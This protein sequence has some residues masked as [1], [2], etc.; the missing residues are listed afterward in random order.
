MLKK[1][2]ALVVALMMAIA[3][4]AMADIDISTMTDEELE[5]LIADAR[6]ELDSR[7]SN[8]DG[9]EDVYRFPCVILDVDGYKLEVL[10]VSTSEYNGNAMVNLDVIA[11]NTSEYDIEIDLSLTTIGEW[12]F[13][14]KSLSEG[15]KVKSGKKSKDTMMF[16]IRDFDVASVLSSDFEF[17][18]SVW[19]EG[20]SLHNLY[21]SA[22]LKG[23]FE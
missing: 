5:A 3:G 13:S 18:V 7:R 17:E 15:V 14:D 2:F 4:S 1:I 21:R 19:D 9:K 12:D 23:A 10:N 22:P 16:Y 6:T 8:A 20:R 11:E